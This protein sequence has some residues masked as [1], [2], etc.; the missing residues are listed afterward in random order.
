MITGWTTAVENDENGDQNVCCRQTK[1]RA[2]G[3]EAH[4]DETRSCYPTA[5]AGSVSSPESEECPL[6][7]LPIF[8]RRASKITICPLST[9]QRSVLL[10]FSVDSLCGA[11]TYS[12]I[13]WAVFVALEQRCLKVL[14]HCPARG[15][16]MLESRGLLAECDTRTAHFQ[17]DG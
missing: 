11:K 12:A 10:S 17:M 5:S 4:G 7:P 6:R 15:E 13:L 14:D 3:L 8:W 16:G 9:R 2:Q 1:V